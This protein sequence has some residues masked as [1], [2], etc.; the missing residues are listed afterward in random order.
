MLATAYQK[1]FTSLSST[2]SGAT[3]QPTSETFPVPKIRPILTVLRT[4]KILRQT[5]TLEKARMTRSDYCPSKSNRVQ[6]S[7]DPSRSGARKKVKQYAAPIASTMAGLPIMGNTQ[8]RLDSAKLP[9][10]RGTLP[11]YHHQQ[12]YGP[13]QNGNASRGTRSNPTSI[14]SSSSETAFDIDLP[15]QE[16]PELIPWDRDQ[17]VRLES[18]SAS[19]RLWADGPQAE[20]GSKKSKHTREVLHPGQSL[21]VKLK[22]TRN[23]TYQD[24]QHQS[25]RPEATAS[26]TPTPTSSWLPNGQ[27]QPSKGPGYGAAPNSLSPTHRQQSSLRQ[28]SLEREDTVMSS[29]RQSQ[30]PPQESVQA[31]TNASDMLDVV[32]QAPVER[33]SPQAE[34]SP[35]AVASPQASSDNNGYA[36]NPTTARPSVPSTSPDSTK[37]SSTSTGAVQFLQGVAIFVSY[38]RKDGEEAE[39]ICTT[40]PEDII[41]GGGFFDS[42]SAE[43]KRH[44]GEDETIVQADATRISKSP[45]PGLMTDFTIVRASKSTIKW[46]MFLKGLERI[47]KRDNTPVELELGICLLVRKVSGQKPKA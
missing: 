12:Q 3:T 45:V 19:K 25:L 34:D 42:L 11:Q 15:T 33:Q 23:K 8:A 47:Y 5:K 41:S 24:M 28:Q 14:S 21:I 30:V 13:S 40:K 18:R 37:A 43:L 22:L 32:E 44:L 4:R 7:D 26:A 1:D 10:S 29:S 6:I 27:V 31:A 16:I 2:K 46:E 9:S 39:H 36:K 38:H 20:A 17:N 35:P